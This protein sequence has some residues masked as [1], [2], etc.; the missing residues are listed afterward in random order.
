MRAPSHI[1]RSLRLSGI[2]TIACGLIFAGFYLYASAPP[3]TFNPFCTYSIA[4]RLN[5][6]IETGGKQYSSTVT[7]KFSRARQKW[8]DWINPWCQQPLGTALAFRLDDNRLVLMATRIC[9]KAK[10]AKDDFTDAMNTKRK[11]DVASSC[12]GVVHDQPPTYPAPVYQA[13]VIDNAEHPAWYRGLAFDA[14]NVAR[15]FRI[16]SAEAMASYVGSEDQ[17]DKVAPAILKTSF[18]GNWSES[19]ERLIDFFRRSRPFRYIA[20]PERS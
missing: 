10:Y 18:N 13:F 8:M 6:T 9:P 4:Y 16:V 17:L 7:R 2:L 14:N 1:K 20:E 5:V 3:H 15:S 11:V 12:R 19:P